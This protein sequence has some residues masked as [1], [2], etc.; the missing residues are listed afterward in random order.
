MWSTITRFHCTKVTTSWQTFIFL[1]GSLE[2]ISSCWFERNFFLLGPSNL[3][4]AIKS[5]IMYWSELCASL[6]CYPDM[7]RNSMLNSIF[8]RIFPLNTQS[9]GERRP[10]AVNLCV[11]SQTKLLLSF[12]WEPT[13]G[14]AGVLSSGP[15]SSVVLHNCTHTTNALILHRLPKT[16]A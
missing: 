2:T 12:E 5:L 6:A 15:S 14:G 3:L 11:A 9:K 8:P 4:F 10:H 1:W 7:T 16:W 13:G